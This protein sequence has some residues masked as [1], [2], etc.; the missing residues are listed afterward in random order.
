[1]PP[2]FRTYQ[3][4]PPPAPGSLRDTSFRDA[5]NKATLE[6]VQRWHDA[7]ESLAMT[8]LFQTT[9]RDDLLIPEPGGQ[10]AQLLRARD[11]AAVAT[12]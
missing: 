7:A 8:W 11:V 4:I 9:R 6:A 12:A 3:I 10:R 1:M 5:L 2:D